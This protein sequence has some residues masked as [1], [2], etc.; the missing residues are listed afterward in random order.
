VSDE[1]E[2]DDERDEGAES[3]EET[4]SDGSS[5][6]NGAGDS[7]SED[8]DASSDDDG[9]DGAST[10]P[11]VEA[12]RAATAKASSG[13]VSS[14]GA[15]LAAAKAA[16]AAVKAA[17]KQARRD[18]AGVGQSAAEREAQDREQTRSEEDVLKDSPL[19][20]AA[21]RAGEWTAQNR[22][23][24]MGAAAVA[25]I[26]L[27]GWLGWSMWTAREAAAAGGLLAEALRISSAQIVAADAAP[28]THDDHDEDAAPTFETIAARNEA[29]LA[30]Y[31]RVV[32]EHA[33]S[34][35]AAWARLGEG[36]TLFAQGDN[37][38]ARTAYQAAFDTSG[39]E[40]V[41]AWQALEGV[42]A[43]YEA[44][45]DWAHATSTYERLS[46][47]ADHAYQSVA[48][49]HLARMHAASG[50]EAAALTAFREL[51]DT[52]REEGEEGE[53]PFPYVLAQAD[54]RLRELDPSAAGAGPHL[55]G[56][57]APDEGGGGG[58]PL[59]G[60]SPEEIQQLIQRLQ[61][62][63]GGS[64]GGLPE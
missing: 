64:G 54:Q 46:S 57:G 36:R 29:A 55:G 13:R 28:A 37:A 21:T 61:T 11:A 59:E 12:V 25:A 42:G 1:D 34:R 7:S 63:S 27:V 26:A 60:L 45:S 2:R 10:S 3:D 41:V 35:A 53:P 56:G 4:S 20:R 39:D 31:R 6:A 50:D 19:G 62:K 38:G 18:E 23:M 58:N 24:A 14:P 40:S 51:V 17:K 43:T 52:L 47:L 5:D 15:R 30:A 16:K 49:Y 48:S 32:S 44:E 9:D 22:Q 8:R 33:G